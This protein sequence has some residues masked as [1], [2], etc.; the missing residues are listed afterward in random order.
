MADSTITTVSVYAQIQ[1]TVA[2][3]RGRN[4]VR[5]V[6]EGGEEGFGMQNVKCE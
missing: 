1:T 5:S 3:E 6:S 2:R 4:G